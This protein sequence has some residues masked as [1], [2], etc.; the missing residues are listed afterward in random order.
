MHV[1]LFLITISK[2]YDDSTISEESESP[3]GYK[4][5]KPR[6]KVPREKFKKLL[7]QLELKKNSKNFSNILNTVRIEKKF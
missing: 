2:S 6:L 5:P 3:T 1:E 7:E 4:Q